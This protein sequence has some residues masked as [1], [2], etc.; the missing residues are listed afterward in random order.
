MIDDSDVKYCCI[1]P[2]IFPPV[3]HPLLS[4]PAES[5]YHKE[6]ISN[7]K[8]LRFSSMKSHI[9][10][11][12]QLGDTSNSWLSFEIRKLDVTTRLFHND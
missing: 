11:R 5:Q 3:T 6:E 10:R 12:N 1:G 2:R 8:S 4:H 7:L 9:P